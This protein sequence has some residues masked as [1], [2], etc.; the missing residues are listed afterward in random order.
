MLL[1]SGAQATIIKESTTQPGVTLRDVGIETDAILLALVV[2]SITG[3][4]DINVY[5]VADGQKSLLLSFPQISAATTS[6]LLRRSAITTSSVHIEVIYS[7]ICSYSLQAR[8]VG[9]GISDTKILGAAGWRVSQQTIGTTPFLLIP[10]SFSDRAG[11][12]IRNWSSTQTIYIAESSTSA[13]IGI[14]YPLAPKE[15]LAVDVAAG[16]EVWGASDAAGADVR[17]VEAGG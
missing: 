6:V 9:N 1:N 4:L 7:G 15:T 17:I 10:I 5:S 13:T 12:L 2:T 8:A 14:G 16:A 3:T 11:L